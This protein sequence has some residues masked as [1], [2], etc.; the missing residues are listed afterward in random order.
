MKK[1]YSLLIFCAALMTMTQAVAQESHPGVRYDGSITIDLFGSKTTLEN[2]SVYI[3]NSADGTSCEFALYDFSLDGESSIGSIE[4]PN[5]KIVSGA[6]NTKNYSGAKDGIELAE[7]DIIANCT[8]DG[9]E[10]SDGTMAMN[11]HVVWVMDPTNPESNVPIEVT[12]N[13]KKVPGQDVVKFAFV[14]LGLPS[15][16]LWANMNVGASSEEDPGDY[17]GWGEVDGGKSDYSWDT[18][19]WCNGTQDIMTKYVVDPAYGQVDNKTVLDIEDDIAAVEEFAGSPTTVDFEE[20][21]NKDNC[22]WELETINGRKGARVTGKNGNSIFLPAG[23]FK[24]GT[25][26]STDNSAGCFWS[27]SLCTTQAKYYYNANVMRF[28]VSRNNTIS[29]DPR[30]H[31][32]MG[33]VPRN[34]GYNVRPVKHTKTSGIENV[35]VSDAKIIKVY[36]L[37]GME[38]SEPAKGL[39]IVVYSNGV[40][41]KV[42]VK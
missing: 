23:G 36:N 2:Q 28:G 20:L 16:T 29:I 19:K 18:Y 25:R 24:T 35:E 12:F 40:T 3:V 31:N 22:T 14:D 32:G 37:N 41:K 10:T 15:G 30:D 27:N 5:V 38:L 13:G 8:L 42:L 34:Y 11:I 9:T 39:N 7:G 21:L 6:D 1:I 4:V 33:F 26:H 17:V